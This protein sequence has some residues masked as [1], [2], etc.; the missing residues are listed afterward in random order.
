MSIASY[1]PW[2]EYQLLFPSLNVMTGQ[3]FL[4]QKQRNFEHVS[5]GQH[6]SRLSSEPESE[7]SPSSSLLAIS[8]S[9][10][11][12]F[13]SAFLLLMVVLL[14]CLFVR[15][16]W[17]GEKKKSAR[18]A[19]LISVY[20]LAVVRRCTLGPLP[21]PRLP[22]IQ[23]QQLQQRQRRVWQEQ[24]R[25]PRQRSPLYPPKPSTSSATSRPLRSWSV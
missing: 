12:V 21:P 24:P 1:L 5:R 15:C 8:I 22:N 20:D 3:L 25:Q 11:S 19:Q 23:C 7:S 10:A 6:T 4:E 13:S 9:S 17:L 2:I 14:A 18:V 16:T